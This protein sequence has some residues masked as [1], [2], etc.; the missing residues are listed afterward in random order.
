MN[1]MKLIYSWLNCFLIYLRTRITFYYVTKEISLELSIINT[2]TKRLSMDLH[3]RTR[4][5]GDLP[6]KHA[7]TIVNWIKKKRLWV[8]IIIRTRKMKKLWMH[9]KMKL[10]I[11]MLTILVLMNVK[12]ICQSTSKRACTA[13]DYIKEVSVKFESKYPEISQ[14]VTQYAQDL[15]LFN[16]AYQHMEIHDKSFNY[17]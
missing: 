4:E 7:C 13:S 12:K 5:N 9:V 14:K 6:R 2:P 10:W 3:Q 11:N 16:H 1:L 8:H 15:H 17:L